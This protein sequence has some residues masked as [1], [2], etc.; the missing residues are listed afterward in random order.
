[1]QKATSFYLNFFIVILL[2]VAAFVIFHIYS[3]IQENKTAA[4]WEKTFGPIEDLPNQYPYRNDN[5]AAIQLKTLAIR[6][7]INFAL[8][9]EGRNFLPQRSDWERLERLRKDRAWWKYL[10]EQL[11]RKDDSVDP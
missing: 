4:N 8:Y 3:K 5:E 9:G 2:V 10:N 1:M 11:G 6:L 7:G